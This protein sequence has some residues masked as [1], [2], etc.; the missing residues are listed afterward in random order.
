MNEAGCGGVP[1]KRLKQTALTWKVKGKATSHGNWQEVVQGS[2]SVHK[3]E[4]REILSSPKFRL[5]D[6]SVDS[7]QSS[8]FGGQCFV[9]SHKGHITFSKF[10]AVSV[11]FQFHL[12]MTSVGSRGAGLP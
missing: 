11:K 4:G 5:G 3:S 1:V 6:S 8:D 12:Y 2:Q 7:S 9:R 10:E